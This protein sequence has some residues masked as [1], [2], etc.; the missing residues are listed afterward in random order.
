[1]WLW[2]LGGVGIGK[3]GWQR[4]L[5]LLIVVAAGGGTSNCGAGEG[6]NFAKIYLIIIH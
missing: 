3:Q 5:W 1:V 2:L 6:I 4:R